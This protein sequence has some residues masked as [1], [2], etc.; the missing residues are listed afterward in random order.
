[1][2]IA[3][4]IH[5]RRIT[6]AG[7]DLFDHAEKAGRRIDAPAPQN[8]CTLPADPP[9]E[10]LQIHDILYRCIARRYAL[11][12]PRIAEETGLWPHTTPADRG[13]KV[14]ELIAVWYEAM[15]VPGM[16]LVS[17][18][19]G[20]WHTADPEE[21]SHYDR[22]LLSRIREIARRDRRLRMAARTAGLTYHGHGHWS[23]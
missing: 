8:P 14:R 10:A 13:T 15:L 22:S 11:T 16:V 7:L 23:A 4:D 18:S 19:C 2:T 3:P 1:V 21:I 20:Y 9:P 5:T 12:A 17:D 6:T